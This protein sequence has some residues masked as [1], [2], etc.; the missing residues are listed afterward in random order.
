MSVFTVTSPENE[1]SV[2]FTSE[3]AACSV[4]SKDVGSR[5]GVQAGLEL[6]LSDPPA[7]VFQVSRSPE[8][9]SV[10]CLFFSRSVFRDQCYVVLKSLEEVCEMVLYMLRTCSHEFLRLSFEQN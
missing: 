7:S 3:E 10:F 8:S 1:T 4:L 6:G 9:L 5:Y 2:V